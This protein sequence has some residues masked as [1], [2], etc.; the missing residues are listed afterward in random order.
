MQVEVSV[1]DLHLPEHNGINL[2]FLLFFLTPIIQREEN[3]IRRHQFLFFSHLNHEVGLQPSNAC[4]HGCVT[5]AG[6]DPYIHKEGRGPS[7]ADLTGE[8]REEEEEEP[9][10]TE[11]RKPKEPEVS[12]EEKD[13]EKK[14]RL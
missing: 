14:V 6:S 5:G 13:R 9:M 1:V 7:S 2:F 8:G 4:I 12:T 3:A 11:A 10:E